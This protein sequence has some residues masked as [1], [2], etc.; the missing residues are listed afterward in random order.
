MSLIYFPNQLHVLCPNEL[1]YMYFWN[2]FYVGVFRFQSNIQTRQWGI[3]EAVN[4]SLR[5]DSKCGQ[6]TKR[7]MLLCWVFFCLFCFVFVCVIFSCIYVHVRHI[8]TEL[9][10]FA[11]R[12]IIFLRNPF[13]S[14][15]IKNDNSRKVYFMFFFLSQKCYNRMTNLDCGL[16]LFLN[17]K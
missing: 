15:Q 14:N 1:E 6:N 5:D 8:F 12:S 7:T 13:Q 3:P 17:L 10:L 16:E 2:I 11:Y 4:S 9:T